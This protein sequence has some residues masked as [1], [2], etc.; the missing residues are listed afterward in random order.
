MVRLT[1]NITLILSGLQGFAPEAFC[2]TEQKPAQQKP[3]RG[4]Y[5][6]GGNW[7]SVSCLSPIKILMFAALLSSHGILE[8]K[9][10]QVGST[11]NLPSGTPDIAISKSLSGPEEN[12]PPLRALIPGTASADTK[13]FSAFT[14]IGSAPLRTHMRTPS[15]CDSL[16]FI[17][18]VRTYQ[19]WCGLLIGSRTRIP[20][21]KANWDASQLPSQSIISSF[22]ET[23]SPPPIAF[24]KLLTCTLVNCRGR[25]QSTIALSSLTVRS[26]ASSNFDLYTS[27]SLVSSAMRTSAAD[28]CVVAADACV[29][30]ADACVVA[31]VARSIASDMAS[32][33]IWLVLDIA[34]RATNKPI[35]NILVER[36]PTCLRSS[37]FSIDSTPA[38]PNT[39]TI[40]IDSPTYSDTSQNVRDDLSGPNQL[41]QTIKAIVSMHKRERFGLFIT[42]SVILLILLAR[43]RKLGR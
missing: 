41:N 21:F 19:L 43:L 10:T 17:R 23:N 26:R 35:I 4:T 3:G 16:G 1:P 38:S 39:P 13:A 33:D 37:S 42:Y 7:K 28:I 31:L 30:A 29:E 24:N 8:K 11:S 34:T 2:T 14:V 40:T 25:S 6:G 5:Q 15:K 27:V 36:L 20:K 32:S 9:S 12:S 22:C 18:H